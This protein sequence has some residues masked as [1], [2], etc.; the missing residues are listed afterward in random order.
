MSEETK[1]KIRQ[2]AIM[3]GAMPPSRKGAVQSEKSRLL[4]SKNMKGRKVWNEGIKCPQTSMD[5]NGSW[6]GG[7][8][9]REGGY[10]AIKDPTNPLSD[11]QGYIKEHRKIASNIESGLSKQ[12]VVHHINGDVKD[13]RPENLMIFKNQSEHMK[14]HARTR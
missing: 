8:I 3:R 12:E 11:K 2:K 9:I 5:K 4:M 13:N 10:I 7:K 14:Y 6:K 1:E